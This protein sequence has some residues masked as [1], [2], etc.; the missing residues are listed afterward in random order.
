LLGHADDIADVARRA[1]DQLLRAH[2]VGEEA[3]ELGHELVT[4]G[5]ARMTGLF[6]NGGNEQP[7]HAFNYDVVAFADRAG[8]NDHSSYRLDTPVA[9]RFVHTNEQMQTIKNYTAIYGT[10]LAGLS[11]ILAK[12]YVR[13]LFRQPID[14]TGSTSV[15]ASQRDL[16]FGQ[17]ALT[18]LNEFG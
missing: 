16:R 12:V 2:D 5:H 1:L 14:V 11:R 4:Y 6:G 18:G 3:R 17:A 10:S 7:V 13:K 15:A 9:Y 8:S